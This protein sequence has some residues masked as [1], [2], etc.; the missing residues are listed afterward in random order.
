MTDSDV[1]GQPPQYAA[2][3]L[4][5]ALIEDPRTSEQGVRV[6]VRGTHVFLTGHV[7]SE[8][9]RTRLDEVI[10]EVAPGLRVHNEVGVVDCREPAEEEEL[11]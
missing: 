9:R 4:R 2:Q 10:R 7:A 5:Q 3:R 6:T 11:R 8:E 1:S